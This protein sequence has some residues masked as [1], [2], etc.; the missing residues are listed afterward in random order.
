MP[1]CDGDYRFEVNQNPYHADPVFNPSSCTAC[2]CATPRGG[3]CSGV[4]N[5][6]Y[7]KEPGC[8][9]GDLLTKVDSVLSDGT[10][11]AVV[12]TNGLARSVKVPAMTLDRSSVACQ[13]LGGFESKSGFSWS[14]QERL[15][16]SRGTDNLSCANA[17]E[18]CVPKVPSSFAQG[19]C[20]Y[21]EGDHA[22]PDQTYANKVLLYRNAVDDRACSACT[23]GDATGNLSCEGFLRQFPNDD[24][25]EATP[26][27]SESLRL[28]WGQ[29][30]TC[31]DVSNFIP[32]AGVPQGV[33]LEVEVSGLA[34]ASCAPSGGQPT[35]QV[36]GSDPVTIC[37]TGS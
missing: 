24:C 32:P 28:T 16:R 10:C 1:S 23:C 11:S 21:R 13:A 36:K 14:Q 22:C 8:N 30:S 26:T 31:G 2:S 29:P 5:V 9:A 33:S 35:G 17:G 15:C 34:Q 20:V 18:V 6:E 7:F 25:T 27:V 3:S 37:C 19:V 4:S 12:G